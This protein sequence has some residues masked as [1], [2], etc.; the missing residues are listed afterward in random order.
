MTTAL[1]RADVRT[2]EIF[3]EWVDLQSAIDNDAV[4]WNK[5]KEQTKIA[6]QIYRKNVKPKVLNIFLRGMLD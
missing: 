3:K 4:L 1:P 5:L 2:S 6:L